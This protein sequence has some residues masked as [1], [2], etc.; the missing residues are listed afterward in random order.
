MSLPLAENKICGKYIFYCLSIIPK[1]NLNN[2]FGGLSKYEYTASML[3]W[4]GIDRFV[5]K[6]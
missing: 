2:Y 4:A 6:C 3:P 5:I 1:C